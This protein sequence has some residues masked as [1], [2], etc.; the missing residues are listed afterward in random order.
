MLNVLTVMIPRMPMSGM[1]TPPL[2]GIQCGA[3]EYS[4]G[5]QENPNKKIEAIGLSQNLLSGR[6]A[7]GTKTFPWRGALSGPKHF[8]QLA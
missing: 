2:D 6:H 1:R 5:S 7:A 8:H 4:G 3:F